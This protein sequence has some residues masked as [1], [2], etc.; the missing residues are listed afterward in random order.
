MRAI[1][2]GSAELMIYLNYRK[3]LTDPLGNYVD[4]H[5]YPVS[6]SHE[7]V[8]VSHIDNDLPMTGATGP[9]FRNHSGAAPSTKAQLATFTVIHI[10]VN[11][12]NC[13]GP[14][15]PAGLAQAVRGLA[16][17]S[18]AGRPERRGQLLRKHQQS[19]E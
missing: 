14:M 10:T 9:R 17:I 8:L 11:A 19:P 15:E 16:G 7:S 12:A 5:L 1:R 3:N 2:G 13:W 4:G 18:R 6:A